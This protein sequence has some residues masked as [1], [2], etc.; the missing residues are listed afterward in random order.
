M[1]QGQ[2]IVDLAGT[3]GAAAVVR[4]LFRVSDTACPWEDIAGFP[5]SGEFERFARWVDGQVRSGRAEEVEVQ[6]SV[7]GASLSLTRLS[8]AF[9]CGY[10]NRD[11]RTVRPP[12]RARNGAGSSC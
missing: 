9:S 5:T 11:H 7:S 3:P 6:F 4:A 12:R 10:S 1:S 2:N 8:A